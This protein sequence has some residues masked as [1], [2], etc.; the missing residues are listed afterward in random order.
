[1]RLPRR[2]GL[3]TRSVAGRSRART[4]GGDRSPA[5]APGTATPPMP[6]DEEPHGD[7]PA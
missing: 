5:R 7:G 6:P 2:R 1:V 4:S 3:L